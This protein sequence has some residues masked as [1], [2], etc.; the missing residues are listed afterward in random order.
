ML[1]A[2]VLWE[3]FKKMKKLQYVGL[4]TRER[5]GFLFG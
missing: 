4:I 3:R 1:P 5:V 2:V